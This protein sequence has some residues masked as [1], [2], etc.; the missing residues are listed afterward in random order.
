MAALSST[1]VLPTPSLSSTTVSSSGSSIADTG[2]TI[3]GPPGGMDIMDEADMVMPSLLREV[4][5]LARTGNV[6]IYNRR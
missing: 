6:I 5:D 1:V 4:S 3:G 2:G